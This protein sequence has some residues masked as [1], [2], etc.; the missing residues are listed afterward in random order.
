MPYDSEWKKIDV[1]GKC[2]HRS[3]VTR[4]H[5]LRQAATAGR[6]LQAVRRV[7]TSAGA[8]NAL[9]W[10]PG[11]PATAI[12]CGPVACGRPAKIGVLLAAWSGSLG[13]PCKFCL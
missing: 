6:A 1:H 11:T 2:E 8:A 3:I 4:A 9:K 13:H 5:V 12:R 10:P 7:K